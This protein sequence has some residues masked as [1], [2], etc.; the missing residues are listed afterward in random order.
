MPNIVF[1][2]FEKTVD[3]PVS[4]NQTL[5]LVFPPFPILKADLRYLV[6]LKWFLVC[7]AVKLFLLNFETIFPARGVRFP[8][9]L[10]DIN[11]IPF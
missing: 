5:E 10:G 8:V 7:A 2:K 11:I 4:L 3:R 9:L 6:F 1:K